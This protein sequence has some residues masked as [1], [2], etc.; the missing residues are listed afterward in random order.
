MISA[1]VEL[2]AVERGVRKMAC[3]YTAQYD[4]PL[5]EITLACNKEAIIGLRFNGQKHFGATLPTEGNSTAVAP[6]GNRLLVPNGHPPL[7]SNGYPLLA[8]NGHQ[9]SVSNRH[10]LLTPERTSVVGLEQTPTTNP[11][12]TPATGRCPPLAGSLFF[13]EEA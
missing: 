8:L 13:R 4:S 1:T 10:Q 12:R 6:S 3:L 7:A 11:E 5:G 9:L 2:S